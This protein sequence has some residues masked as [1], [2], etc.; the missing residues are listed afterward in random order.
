MRQV[1]RHLYDITRHPNKPL[2]SRM[3]EMDQQYVVRTTQTLYSYLSR[4]TRWIMFGT[5]K[6]IRAEMFNFETTDSNRMLLLLPPD[7]PWDTD[8]EVIL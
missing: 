4:T 8:F 3:M 2:F 7:V 5:C 6:E 1:C